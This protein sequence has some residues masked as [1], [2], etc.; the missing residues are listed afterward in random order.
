MARGKIFRDTNAGPGIVLVD[1]VQK[2]FELEKHW[3]AAV[4]PRVG[5]T[6]EVQLDAQGEISAVQV[7]DEA[8]LAKEQALKA[9]AVAQSQGGTL[10]KS[11]RARV[12]TVTL[13]GTLL[14]ALAWYALPAV[15]TAAS[16]TRISLSLSE[17]LGFF[18]AVRNPM[19]AQ[20]GGGSGLYGVLLFLALLAPAAS[21]FLQHRL[22]SL[23]Y[24]APMAA[25]VLVLLSSYLSIRSS[26]AAMK[27]QMGQIGGFMGGDIA[28]STE[29]MVSSMMSATWDAMSFG[30]GLYLGFLVAGYFAFL[31]VRRA[32][33][34][35]A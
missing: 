13:V 7:I 2:S 16:G 4:P 5:D 17:T 30:S 20:A 27:S 3:K 35:A 10:V 12:G 32:L 26:L 34:R 29:K 14:L 1:G 11:L 24:L 18:N 33:A 28:R 21:H 22:A 31:G 19:A 8:A 9:L 25:M 15:S 23:A 6:V